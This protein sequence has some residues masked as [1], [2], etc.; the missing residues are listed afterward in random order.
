MSYSLTVASDKEERGGNYVVYRKN[1]YL[2]FSIPFCGECARRTARSTRFGQALV[3][4]GILIALV[5]SVRFDVG[6]FLG[7]CLGVGLRGVLMALLKDHVVRISDYTDDS[8]T[9]RF[10]NTAY[11][12]ELCKLNNPRSSRRVGSAWSR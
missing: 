9:F 1:K 7:W 3:I 2:T 4:L 11:A 10:K 12:L 8:V 5:I 6:R